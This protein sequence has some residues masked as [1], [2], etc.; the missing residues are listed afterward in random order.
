MES[1]QLRASRRGYR[2]HLTRVFGKIASILDSD[3]PPNER[4]TATLQTS[5]EQIETTRATVAELDTK[6][7]AAITDA[8][9]LESEI[10]DTQEVTYNVAEK[11]TFI[12]A[13]L[14]R[15]RPLNVR[16]FSGG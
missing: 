14:A 7:Q 10:L 1:A 15:P 4:E 5:L 11:I 13:V 12:K 6:I 8:D 16:V 3:E 2:A 9:A